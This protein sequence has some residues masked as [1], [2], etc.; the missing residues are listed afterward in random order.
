MGVLKDKL[1][2][3]NGKNKIEITRIID[4]WNNQKVWLV[5]HYA[6]GHYTVNQEVNSRILYSRFRRMTK[7]QLEAIFNE[8]RK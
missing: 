7:M 3:R 2:H 6:D 1:I 4:K 8:E 5:K